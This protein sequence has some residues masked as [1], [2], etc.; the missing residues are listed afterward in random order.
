MLIVS[1]IILYSKPIEYLIYSQIQ[2]NW[3]Q[4]DT[5]QSHSN[6]NSLLTGNKLN[7]IGFLFFLSFTNSSPSTALCWRLQFHYSSIRISLIHIT[8]VIHWQIDTTIV[9]NYKLTHQN[10]RTSTSL[11][12]K[13]KDNNWHKRQHNTA[14]LLH[15]QEHPSLRTTESQKVW[16]SYLRFFS[17]QFLTTYWHT[18]P[19]T[20]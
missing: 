20:S 10:L 18:C 4:I 13:S 12:F 9:N 11:N 1:S 14:G 3:I 5:I 15:K 19:L 8:Q 17:W 7:P 6:L 16:F 2:S